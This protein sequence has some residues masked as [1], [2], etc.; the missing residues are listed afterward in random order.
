MV[1]LHQ[2]TLLIVGNCKKFKIYDT[3]EAQ[4]LEKN[5]KYYLIYLQSGTVV[6]IC[7]FDDEQTRNMSYR[8]WFERN[9]YTINGCAYD[10]LQCLNLVV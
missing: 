3:I 10:E 4:Q 8:S 6:D 7:S 9:E 1:Q 5:M 2:L